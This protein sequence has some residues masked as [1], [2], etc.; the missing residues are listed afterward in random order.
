MLT[1]EH[2]LSAELDRNKKNVP[3][4]GKY[5]QVIQYHDG[6]SLSSARIQIVPDERDTTLISES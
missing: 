2:E 1:G 4:G 6:H 3:P 5:R